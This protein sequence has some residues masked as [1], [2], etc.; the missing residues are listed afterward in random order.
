MNEPVLI[1]SVKSSPR[2]KYILNIILKDVLG[3]DF[4]ITQ[5]PVQFE[6]S[7]SAKINY[8]LQK[9]IKDGIKV[10]PVS[11]LFE[12]GIKDHLIE[13]HSHKDY[14]KLFFKTHGD[15]QFDILAASFWLLTRYEEYLPFKQDKYNRFDVKNSL[16]FQ[17]DFIEVPLVNLWI[18]QF[19]KLL[20]IKFPGLKFKQHKFSY[21]STIDIDNAYKFKY[22]GV[23]REAGGY[24][25]SIVTRNFQEIKERTAVILNKKPDPFDSYD[26]LLETQR[27]NNLNVLY[28]FLLGDYGV[29]DKNHPAN[30]KDFKILIK[31]L[32]DYA[33][34]G[35]HPSYKSNY[36]LKQLKIEVNRLANIT[37]ADVK[38]SRQHFAILKFPETYLALLQA[39]ITAD[40]S[41]GYGNYNGFRASFCIPYNWYDLDSEQETPLIIHPFCIIETTLRFTN[42]ATGETAMQFA[43]PIIDEVQKYNGELVTIIHNDTMGSVSEWKGWKEVYENI[44]KEAL[45]KY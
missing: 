6:Q 36:N 7:E 42:K 25:K 38:N 5:N 4:V 19:K 29:N 1:Y 39:G 26:F 32:A 27:K 31:H 21:I 20:I 35:I 12:Y 10:V 34:I 14:A 28:F 2:L 43:K 44:V 41:M 33:K 30:N 17:Y 13:V 18:E 16:A 9:F 24:L 8:S 3:L 37:H 11:L 22:K 45:K 23:M 40:Y 15:L